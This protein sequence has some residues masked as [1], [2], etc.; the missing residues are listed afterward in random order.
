MSAKDF[1]G[2]MSPLYGLASGH[3]M[4]GKL[5][6]GNK[7]PMP[8]PIT[9]NKDKGRRQRTEQLIADEKEKAKTVKKMRSGG[10][11]KSGRCP[12][13]GVAKRGRTKG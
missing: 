1:L 8:A 9:D 3:G 11:V 13:D 6:G 12:R 7:T 5:A 2:S 10:M 4:F